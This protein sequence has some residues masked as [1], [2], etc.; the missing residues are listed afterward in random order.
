MSQ[1]AA[2]RLLLIHADDAR[3]AGLTRTL[4]ACGHAVVFAADAAEAVR[5]LRANGPF[6]TVLLG[7]SS[8]RATT[9]WREACTW[10]VGE[11]AK[12]CGL[13]QIVLLAEDNLDA[14][15]SCDV[16]R[17]GVFGFVDAR[18]GHC[19]NETLERQLR[20][21][22]ERYLRLRTGVDSLHSFGP[23]ERNSMVGQSPI[24]ADLLERAARAARVSDVPVLIYGE[25]GTGKQ[26]LAELIHQLDPKRGGKRF[27]SVNCSAIS[28]TLAES[29][30]F[31]H[32]RG[33]YTGAT[34]ARKGIFRAAEG[35]T[36]LLDEIGDM[37]TALQ[38]KLLRVLQE[39]V[40][41]PLGADVEVPSDVR[42][43]AATNRRLAALVEQDLFRLDLYQRLDVIRLEI[44]PL[45]ERREDI[46]ALVQFFVKKYADYYDG[47]IDTVDASVIEFFNG[48]ALAGNVRELENTV[49]QML[50]FKTSGSRLDISDVPANLLA[51]DSRKPTNR[52]VLTELADVACQLVDHG[53]MTLPELVSE[54]EKL[55]LHKSMMRSN[56]NSSDLAK[57]LG[58]SRRTLYNKIRKYRLGEPR[59]TL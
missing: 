16:L 39:G 17:S 49:R 30:L 10:T 32:V 53:T 34:T 44:P 29:T 51:N 58:L 7:T 50:A 48:A 8:V 5:N 12:H 4:E 22:R 25:S 6:A 15:L 37:D 20:A 31:G 43:L 18:N 1:A 9:A 14:Q 23:G 55:V 33:A 57:R 27:L 24:M 38:P 54:C 36:V 11:L 59:Q 41:M 13:A 40:V 52:S 3:R 45:R 47:E 19:D 2:D 28:G 42:V 46:P 35:G 21:A 56:L 26:L